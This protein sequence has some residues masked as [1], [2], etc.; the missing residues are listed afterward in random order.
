M[1]E[2]HAQ[3]ERQVLR[4]EHLTKSFVQPGVRGRHRVFHA[5]RDVSFEIGA[6]RSYGLVG[7]TGSGK[8]TLAR[9]VVGLAGGYEGTIT[10]GDQVL[11]PLRPRADRA[12]RTR[13]Q[14]VFQDAGGSLDSRF[15]VRR[16]I[17]EPL[18]IHRIG[19]PEERHG[20]ALE[21]LE[22]V[23]IGRDFLDRMPHQLSGGQRQRVA[24]ARALVLKPQLLVMDEPVSALDVS[25]QAQII[26]LLVDLQNELGLSYLFITHDLA[27]AEYFC[28]D[29]GV[30]YHGDLV[31]AGSAQQVLHS[32]R[33]EYTR[34]LVG[35][36]PRR[37]PKSPA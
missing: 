26:N 28:D 35:A 27:I 24:L 1:P 29:I 10:L 37:I 22:L 6:R 8:S 30:L 18:D 31:E 12:L 9:C 34:L 16:A 21:A 5:L 15:S 25:I 23:G 33:H 2:I 13:L 20:R 11:D 4:V 32:P 7:E 17:R 36:A 14:M 19:V 3:S